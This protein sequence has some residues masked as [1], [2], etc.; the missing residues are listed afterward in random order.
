MA[1]SIDKCIQIRNRVDEVG[2]YETSIEYGISMESVK[3]A[4]RLLKKEL[5]DEGDNDSAKRECRVNGQHTVLCIG[6][7]H[8][9]FDLDEYFEFCSGVADEC[10]PT[11]IVFIGDVIDN[12]YASYHETDPDGM[13]GRDELDLAIDRLQR[14]YERFPDAYVTIGNHDRMVMRKS[15]TSHIPRRWIK[16]Y[17]EVLG[18]PGWYF[19]DRVDIDGVQYIHGEAGTAR[20][21]CRADMM[22]TVQ[23]HLHTQAYVDWAVGRRFRVFGMQVGCGIDFSSYA[24]AYAKSGK[25]PAIG[26]GIII[27]GKTAIN[28]MMEL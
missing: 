26:C 16:S 3:R 6:D 4:M 20:T 1:Y 22:S 25:K 12:H 14:W 28:R 9:P 10:N 5:K 27:N 11:Q 23:G 17:A 2:I 24:M 8:A 18:T 15:Q 7:L 21:K 19:T 13:G